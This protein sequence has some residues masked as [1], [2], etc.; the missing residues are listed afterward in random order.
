MMFERKAG[1]AT[2]MYVEDC[3][4]V[5]HRIACMHA[6]REVVQQRNIPHGEEMY[7]MCW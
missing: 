5:L 7:R 1:G 2:K 6:V 4:L 3:A